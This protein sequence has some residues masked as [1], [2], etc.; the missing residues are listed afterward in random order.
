[1]PLCRTLFLAAA[2]AAPCAAAE[3]TLLWTNGDRMP[4][5]WLGADEGWL[6]WEAAALAEPVRVWL[7]RL[8][9]WDAGDKVAR[10]TALDGSWLLRLA[11]GSFFSIGDPAASAGSWSLSN[12]HAGAL[13][14]A[15]G[16]VVE[17]LRRQPAGPLGY[18]GPGGEP[19]WIPENPG[20][21]AGESWEMTPGGV[22]RTRSIDQA[23]ALPL[24]LPERLRLDLWLRTEI[25]DRPPKFRLRLRR[26]GQGLELETWLEE[27]VGLGEGAPARLHT[28]FDSALAVTLCADF[29]KRRAAAYDSAG[30]ELGAW[31][32][33]GLM[34]GA[35]APKRSGKGG[36][37]GALAEAVAQGL[38]LQKRAAAV[39]EPGQAGEIENG[40]MLVN[41][42]SDLALER[43][44]L[45][46]WDGQPPSPRPSKTP[47]VELLDGRV[48]AGAVTSM[49]DG[50]VRLE[51]KTEAKLADVAWI[52]WQPLRPFQDKDKAASPPAAS[53]RARYADGSFFHGRL[54]RADAETLAMQPAWSAAPVTLRR[55]DLE[56]L[57]WHEPEPLAGPLTANLSHLD[58]LQRGKN[59]GAV[60]GVWVPAPGALPLWRLDGAERAV[61]IAPAEVWSLRKA[62]PASAAAPAKLPGM[63]Y[64]ANGEILPV[65]VE[66]WGEKNAR[67]RSPL[68]ADSRRGELPLAAIRAL[69]LAGPGLQT[70]DF[71]DL[72][73]T[74][75]HGGERLV[76]R[77]E[78]GKSVTLEAGAAFGHGSFLQGTQLNFALGGDTYSSLRLRVFCE[79]ANAKSPHLALLI[80]RSG[81]TA[82]CGVENPQRPGQ[83]TGNYFRIPIP[84]NKPCPMMLKWNTK[85]LEF[86]VNGS[87]AFRQNLT[88]KV[89]SGTGLIFEPA[90]LWGN[91]V[92]ACTLT[93]LLLRAHPGAR[94]RPTL[95]AE[96]RAWA[97]QVPRRLADDPPRHLLLAA[98]GDLLRG[99]L[100]AMDPRTLTLRQGLERFELPRER[101]A[102]VVLPS[103]AKEATPPAAGQP[104]SERPAL[105]I[106]TSE[107]ARLRLEVTSLGPEWVEGRSEPLGDCRLPAALVA[108]LSTS[109]ESQ[110]AGWDDWQFTPAPEPDL[111]GGGESSKLLGA[112]APDFELPLAGGGQFKLKDARGQVVVLDFWAS[113]CG[114]CLAALPETMTALKAFPPERVRLLAVNQG[115]PKEEVTAFL[116][117]RGWELPTALDLDRKVGTQYGAGSIPHTV[118]VGPDGKVAWVQT[119]HSPE[120]TAGLVKAVRALLDIE[121]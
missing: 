73:W 55:E 56:S 114:P 10:R 45:R 36:L 44:L 27:L 84:S 4:G 37:F 75:L 54:L 20:K 68:A 106:S 43:V 62:V 116:R 83:M 101:V 88:D 104:A 52:S 33:R 25:K 90:S 21:A 102:L 74:A 26:A 22:L 63:A 30:R 16:S 19:A 35:A 118:V 119:G 61:A 38:A 81:S 121:R 48:L 51:G 70:A 96:T 111:A 95:D 77:T 42:G 66:S 92:R 71:G 18:A 46:E 8:Y 117:A 47:F 57:R 86:H 17:L 34:K 40:L 7:P 91:E 112:Q 49:T 14:I 64:L 82:Y 12:R 32:I 39:K 53:G 31:K 94:T 87:L 79:G 109:P 93:N 3:G 41:T 60:K 100:E 58:L 108:S 85:Q 6:T 50:L 2:L 113:W 97:L 76:K 78:D 5:I 80:Y 69:E 110:N 15:G 1:M 23:I 99:T 103:P 59:G 98:N 115:Q 28:L 29:K 11:D 120:S 13:S 24:E 89:R 105:W 67:I 9:G 107:G 72:G 65:E